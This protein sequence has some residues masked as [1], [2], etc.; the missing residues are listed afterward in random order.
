MI[1]YYDT[2]NNITAMMR[3]T[4][5]PTAIIAQMISDGTIQKHGVFCSEEIVPC[6]SF[7]DELMKR[8]INIKKEVKLGETS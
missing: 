4:G 5:Y 8:N 1:D 6:T 3:T 7:F 2:K